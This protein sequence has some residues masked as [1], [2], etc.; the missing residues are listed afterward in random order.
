MIYP[1][2]AAVGAGGGAAIPDNDSRSGSQ[3][4]AKSA[5]KE[6]MEDEVMETSGDTES[7]YHTPPHVE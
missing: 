6:P 1:E 5:E 3:E 4:K 2:S 7:G